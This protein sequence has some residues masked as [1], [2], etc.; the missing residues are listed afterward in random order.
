MWSEKQNE[1]NKRSRDTSADQS[2]ER[3]ITPG[4]RQK[5]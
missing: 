1:E 2:G 4:D 5:D 3:E